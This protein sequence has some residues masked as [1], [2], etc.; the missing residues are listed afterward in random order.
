[1]RARLRKRIV[2][3][4]GV[5]LAVE[6]VYIGRLFMLQ[7]WQGTAWRARA[8]EQYVSESRELYDRGSIFFESKDGTRVAAATLESGFLLAMHPALLLDAEYTYRALSA[9]IPLDHEDFFTR[10]A[11]KNDPYEE[12][13]HHVTGEDAE[14]IRA[15]KLPGISLFHE[16]W[17]T[18]PGGT[19]GAHVL[20]FVGYEGDHLVGRYGLE[21]YF[22][23]TL[24]REKKNL[25]VNFFAEIFSAVRTVV[26]DGESAIAGDV[27]T[28]IEPNAQ[29]A[30]EREL[31]RVRALFYAKSAGGIVMDPKT[32]AIYALALTPSYNPNTFREEKNM[33]IFANPLVEDRM[34]M[35]SIMKPITMA[36]GI[37]EK[38]VTPGTVY[39]DY[40]SLDLDGYTIKN[41]DGRARGDVAMQE[42]LSQSLN[43]GVAFIAARVGKEKFGTRLAGF[44]F[45]E[46]TGIDLPHEARGDIRNLKSP[47]MLEYATA[48]FGQGIAVTPI[49]MIRALAAL[50]NGGTLVTPHL[51]ERVEGQGGFF[52]RI[53]YDTGPRALSS[54]AALETT[55]ML[56]KVVDTALAQGKE[57]REHYSIAAKT[58]T[59][60]IAEEG[61]R[62][63]YEDRYLHTFFG[64]FPAY[65]PRFIILLFMREPRAQYASETLTKPFMNLTDYLI[66][67]YEVPPDR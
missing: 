65:D 20:G 7:I 45:G 6:L 14:R 4:A 58:G 11:K 5:L 42:V 26:F 38:A 8:E 13:A 48:S 64:Y 49:A 1:M 40:G 54:E 3:L 27:V 31:E 60:Q 12:V 46:E 32:G 57:K 30:L 66:N 22:E 33:S 56:V 19:I 16:R 41:Y 2:I 44:G 21:R 24:Q 67:Y 52:R 15:L 28:S 53:T 55:R 50:A 34:E 61:A 51:A 63:Y 62:G 17:R 9:I 35:G 36:I 43:T 37:D 39:H 10:A 29:L 47:R 23:S 25:D 18:Y 59:A